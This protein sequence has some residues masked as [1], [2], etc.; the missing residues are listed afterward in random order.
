M[1]LAELLAQVADGGDSGFGSTI[2][3]SGSGIVAIV[4]AWFTYRAS[5]DRVRLDKSLGAIE[6]FDKLTEDQRIELDATKVELK[7]TRVALR[8]AEKIV[9][10]QGFKIQDQSRKIEGQE[11]HIQEQEREIASLR[12]RVE[13]LEE[14]CRDL[15]T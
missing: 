12:A 10:E 15:N 11:R 14:K 2:I 13:T 6:G 8:E 9:H 3:A 1:L 4:C 7:D 5:K